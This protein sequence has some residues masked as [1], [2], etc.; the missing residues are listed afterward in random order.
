MIASSSWCARFAVKCAITGVAVTSAGCAR[1][2]ASSILPDAIPTA[3]SFAGAAHLSDSTVLRGA[4][5]AAIIR[6]S[7]VVPAPDD[8]FLVAD[9]SE[10]HVGRRQSD[11]SSAAPVGNAA[12]RKP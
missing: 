1:A 3:H 10:G 6:F 7:N 8:G 5:S 9:A 4:D 11:W 2:D 12:G